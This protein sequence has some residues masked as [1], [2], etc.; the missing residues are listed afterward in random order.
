MLELSSHRIVL[1]NVE[2]L[3][4]DGLQPTVGVV[5]LIV[6]IHVREA[7]RTLGAEYAHAVFA[8]AHGEESVLLG[9]Q[10]IVPRTRGAIGYKVASS[11]AALILNN[12]G[13]GVLNFVTSNGVAGCSVY[14]GGLHSCY[15]VQIVE[16]VDSVDQK[17]P[18]ALLCVPFNIKVLVRLCDSVVRLNADDLAQLAG[19][20]NLTK[21]LVAIGR[22]AMM[23]D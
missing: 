15:E 17:R 19:V 1:L 13:Y 21:Q 12:S 6:Q 11:Y 18:R 20:D 5:V 16:V 2:V 23:A 8:R 3:V 22:A 9:C 14:L 7:E 4:L 10:V